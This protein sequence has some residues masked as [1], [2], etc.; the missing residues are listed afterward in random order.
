[1]DLV[2]GVVFA[3][4]IEA[5]LRLSHHGWNLPG[6]RMVVHGAMVFG[7]LLVSY[8]YLPMEMAGHPWVFGPLLILAMSSVVYGYVR[9]TRQWEPTAASTPQPELQPE[10]V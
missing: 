7:A 6:I 4:T 9:T 1:M 5:A 10:P 8:R 2:A 3:L